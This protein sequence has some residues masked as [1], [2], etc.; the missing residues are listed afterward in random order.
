MS[1]LAET[2]CDNSA[3]ISATEKKITKEE[4]AKSLTCSLRQF[5]PTLFGKKKPKGNIREKIAEWKKLA[6]EVDNEQQ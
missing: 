2:A 5:A 6:E 4:F 1:K 3:D